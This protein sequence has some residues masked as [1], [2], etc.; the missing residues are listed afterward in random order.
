MAFLAHYRTTHCREISPTLLDGLRRVVDPVFLNLGSVTFDVQAGSRHAE[1]MAPV[2]IDLVRLRLLFL[3]NNKRNR[4]QRK[5]L[6]AYSSTHGI[7]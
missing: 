6:S 7:V 1:G 4:N 2:H 3:V 5:I